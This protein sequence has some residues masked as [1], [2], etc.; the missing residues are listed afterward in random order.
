MEHEDTD[1][2][3]YPSTPLDS[4]QECRALPANTRSFD[5]RSPRVTRFALAQD[6]IA[7]DLREQQATNYQLPTTNCRFFDRNFRIAWL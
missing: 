3:Q 6:D 7:E 4:E 5:S 1:Y 2:Q